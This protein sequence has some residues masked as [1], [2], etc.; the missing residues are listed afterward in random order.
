MGVNRNYLSTNTSK[1]N[2]DELEISVLSYIQQTLHFVLK[3]RGIAKIGLLVFA[4]CFCAHEYEVIYLGRHAFHFKHI[5]ESNFIFY[6]SVL[7]KSHQK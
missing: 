2:S 1:Y 7:G 6:A 3:V 4:K 5:I